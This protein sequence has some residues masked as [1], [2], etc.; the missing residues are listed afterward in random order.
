MAT[1][2]QYASIVVGFIA[3]IIW[4]VAAFV[5][6]PKKLTH[7]IHSPLDGGSGFEGDLAVLAKGVRKQSMLNAWAAGF[8]ALA[9]IL[10]AI[11]SYLLTQPN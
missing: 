10:Q 2:F 11:A 5:R 8:T 3:A 9:V 4:L 1:C 7:L 6:T